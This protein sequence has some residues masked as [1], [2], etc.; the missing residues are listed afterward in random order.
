MVMAL[1][2]VKI[3]TDVKS[4]QGIQGAD[5][6][7]VLNVFIDGAIGKLLELRYPFDF[8]KTELDLDPRFNSWVTR[9]TRSIYDSQGQ[10]N[11]S[12]FSQNGVQIT[13][14]NMVEGIDQSLVDSIMP[15][16]GVP[17]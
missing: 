16:V 6:D 14:S 5:E 4:I 10:H 17:K 9:A 11:I 2:K 12:Q 13:Y 1:D 15:M 7:A 3:L 8:S